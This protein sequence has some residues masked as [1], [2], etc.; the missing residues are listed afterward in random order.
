MIQRQLVAPLGWRTESLQDSF[1]C[2]L[3][4]ASQHVRTMRIVETTPSA[5][6]FLAGQS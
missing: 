4:G 6:K 2:A 3:L 5:C 1:L